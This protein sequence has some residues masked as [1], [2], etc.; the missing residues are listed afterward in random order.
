MPGATAKGGGT[1]GLLD[2][3]VDLTG[4]VAM[5]ATVSQASTG[6]KS[7]LLKP[8]NV[9]F[10]PKPAGA[11]LPVSVTGYYPHPKFRVSLT[12]KK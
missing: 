10:K 5:Q 3:K 7:V 4:R 6:I 9:F 12:S 2:K 11:V 1:Y 8:L